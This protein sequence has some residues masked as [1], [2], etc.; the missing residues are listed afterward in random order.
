VR[1]SSSTA[2]TKPRAIRHQVLGAANAS[3]PRLTPLA[4]GLA[5]SLQGA[6]P[7]QQR[8]YVDP[9]G[10]QPVLMGEQFLGRDPIAHVGP[11][12][13]H[14]AEAGFLDVGERVPAS[15]ATSRIFSASATRVAMGFPSMTVGT[16]ARMAAS[17]DSVCSGSG[18]AMTAMSS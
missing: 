5:L 7:V 2:S 13:L 1:L 4:A 17:T 8:P 16:T 15:S 6:G 14:L 3:S 18:V 10:Q 12:S 9:L 11:P